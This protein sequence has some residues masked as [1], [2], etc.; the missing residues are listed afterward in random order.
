MQALSSP[1]EVKDFFE[2]GL[3]IEITGECEVK[4][5]KIFGPDRMLIFQQEFKDGPY[6]FPDKGGSLTIQWQ[7]Q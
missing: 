7:P 6:C 5:A 4:G 1:E 2:N 3:T